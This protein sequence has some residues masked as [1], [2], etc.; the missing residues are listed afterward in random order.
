MDRALPFLQELRHWRAAVPAG[1]ALASCVALWLLDKWPNFA[2]PEEALS[3]AL[4]ATL[5]ALGRGVTLILLLLG[6][7]IAG[8]WWCAAAQNACQRVI[9]LA[10]RPLP[11]SS[12]PEDWRRRHRVFLPFSRHD[13]RRI[14]TLLRQNRDYLDLPG[15][16]HRNIA[17]RRVIDATFDLDRSTVE[18]TGKSSM[19]HIRAI[20][21]LR[22]TTGLI[23]WLP[24]A[25]TLVA[26]HLSESTASAQDPIRASGL[27]V[28]LALV[29]TTRRQVAKLVASS[30]SQVCTSEFL[31]LASRAAMSEGH[32]RRHASSMSRRKQS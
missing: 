26:Q 3:P 18:E 30:V 12:D 29:I 21:D 16:R 23:P 20:T 5:E 19:E 9:S 1:L 17:I 24:L 6:I 31:S 2:D 11:L 27:L 22:A 25:V 8:D 7:V 4:N 32:S 10:I 15:D 28:L 13:L 14:Q